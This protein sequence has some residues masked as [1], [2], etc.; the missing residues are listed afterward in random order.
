MQFL[1]ALLTILW[2]LW[3]HRNLVVHQAK[4]PNPAEVVLTST[5]L[6][7]RHKEAFKEVV[8][9]PKAGLKKQP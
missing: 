5:S 4:I 1:Q 7:C 2:L 9:K 8:H 3:T 6:I